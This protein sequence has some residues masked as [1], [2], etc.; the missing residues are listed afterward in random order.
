MPSLRARWTTIVWKLVVAIS[1][2]VPT[3]LPAQGTGGRILGRVADPTGAVLGGVKVTAVNE[4]TGV[5]RDTQTSDS[6]DYVFPNSSGWNL[7]LS[8]ELAGFKKDVHK[9]YRST[10]IRSSRST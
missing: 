3:L 2:V 10:S 5:G 9:S 1:L 7:Y 8:F 4:A 6:G